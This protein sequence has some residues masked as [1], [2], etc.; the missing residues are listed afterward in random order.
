MGSQGYIKKRPCGIC[1][2]WFMPDPRLKDRQK[3]CGDPV[4]KKEWHRR[5]CA[6]W[7]QANPDYFKTNYLQKKLDSQA[8]TTHV[9]SRLKT[10]LPLERV[11]EVIGMQHLIIIE[12]LAQLLVRRF[13]D[14]I[15]RQVAVN[16]EQVARLPREVFSRCD[17]Q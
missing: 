1:Q 2:R 6:Q 10:G 3:T 17:R 13:Q 15:W 7:N 4:C 16:T 9:K 5:K 14:V 12:Y 11:Q 8:T